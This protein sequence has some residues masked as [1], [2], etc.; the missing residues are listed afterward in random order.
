MIEAGTP[1]AE[2]EGMAGPR[3]IREVL[4]TTLCCIALTWGCGCQCGSSAGDA[5]V[6]AA[7]TTPRE[8]LGQ[9]VLPA[10]T[11]DWHARTG[12]DLQIQESYQGSGAQSRA[13]AE[14]FDADVVLL[15]LAPDVERLVD[16]GLVE[17][18]WDDGESQ[19]IVT[20]SVVV[21]AVRPGNPLGIA[22]WE[23]LARPGIEVLTPNPRT[24]GGAMWNVAAIWGAATHGQAGADGPARAEAL[25]GRILA[26]V[27]VMDKS[28]RDSLVN[29][30]NG[31]GDVAI[32]YENEVIVAQREGREIEYVIPSSTILIENP[33]AVVRASVRKHDTLEL[34][35]AFVA[36][37]H[38][39]ESQEAFAAFGY[40]PVIE[41]VAGAKFPAVENLFTVED[42]GGW[43]RVQD[44]LFGAGAVYDRA[45]GKEQ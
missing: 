45:L 20:R 27:R 8:V 11:R 7:Y 19:G 17:E 38:T 1:L 4:S 31:V 10:F 25:L 12:K 2:G 44:L 42:L 21:I 14:G 26:N 40:R 30:E 16:A 28:A 5:L 9:A 34:A 23:D 15:S 35:E 32:T 36:H 3:L 41:G 18:S 43:D 13:V 29:F 33:V 37:L 22:Q 39:N 6:L 24:S